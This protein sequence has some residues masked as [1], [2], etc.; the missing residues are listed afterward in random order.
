MGRGERPEST[1]HWRGI[2]VRPVCR[3]GPR[4]G[5]PV[6]RGNYTAWVV[7][8]SMGTLAQSVAF[9][10]DG[11]ILASAGMDGWSSGS[12]QLWDVA[13]GKNT[14]T[15]KEHTSYVQSVAFSPDGKTLASGSRDKTVKLWDVASVNKD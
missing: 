1:P 11:K 2:W 5:V 14:A 9:S 12:T 13:S 7:V 3:H 4:I 10:P 8:A 15:L 6:P